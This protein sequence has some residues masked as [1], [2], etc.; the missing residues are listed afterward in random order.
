MNFGFVIQVNKQRYDLYKDGSF[1][2][3]LL[4]LDNNHKV[5]LINYG[6]EDLD[7]DKD[8]FH[9]I[10]R[11]SCWSEGRNLGIHHIKYYCDNI[12]FL[13][14]ADD[15]P[16]VTKGSLEEFMDACVREYVN[17]RKKMFFPVYGHWGQEFNCPND[18]AVIRQITEEKREVVNFSESC[19]DETFKFPQVCNSI[20]DTVDQC[21]LCMHISLIDMYT[22]YVEYKK[23]WLMGALVFQEILRQ[24]GRNHTCL[25]ANLYIHNE[26]NT[27][28]PREN[29]RNNDKA[30]ALSQMEVLKKLY[31]E[32]IKE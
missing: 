25:I 30:L 8:N 4:S 15:D 32:K 17:N 10:K 7:I 3:S 5:V 6:D 28:Y 29:S 26:L 23:N 14:L 13:I 11:K 12:D 20:L 18:W 21:L 27:G 31:V 22:P 19:Y 24:Y 2:K 1:W 16:K 9:I